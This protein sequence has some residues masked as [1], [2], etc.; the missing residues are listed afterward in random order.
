MHGPTEFFD[1]REH[2]LAQKAESAR[3]VVCISEHA[4][5]Q[6]MGLVP[7]SH[8]HKLRV[9]HCSVD[10]GRFAPVDRRGR[11]AREVLT[12]GRAVP[13]K[14]QTLLIEAMAELKRRG[15]DA[16]LTLVG[17][18]PQMPEL[19]ELVERLAVADR[20]D[21]T[22]AV[23]QD[24]IGALYARA[25]VFAM[26]SFAE[27]LPVVLMEAM[28][29]GLPVVASRITGVPELVDD[30]VS[31]LLVAPGRVD[32]LVAALERL[33]G[34]SA[35]EREAMGRAGRERVVAEFDADTTAAQ[36]LAAFEEMA[37]SARR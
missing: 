17:D 8:W 29:T 35:E 16:R 7:T 24:E 3:V 13:V 28:A 26:P 4:R 22:G 32:G 12:V 15:V 36:L 14:G 6:V 20:V 21:L 5:S 1:V 27:G 30:G 31:G 2:R 10:S 25:D 19:R 34:A 18:G 33:L 37:I 23:G 11:G 9:V